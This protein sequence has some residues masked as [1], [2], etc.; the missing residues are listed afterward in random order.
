[1]TIVFS[2]GDDSEE[3]GGSGADAGSAGDSTGPG[4][5][6]NTGGRSSAAGDSSSGGSST[7]GGSKSTMG[8]EAG[9]VS[10]QG[11]DSGAGTGGKAPGTGGAATGG[12]MARGG[13]G[14]RT[15]GGAS[16]GGASN[17]GEGGGSD[18]PECEKGFFGPNCEPCTCVGT[19]T[20]DDGADGDGSCDCPTGYA[21][22]T[23]ADCALGYQDS[24]ADGTCLIACTAQTCSGHGE[25]GYFVGLTICDCQTGYAGDVC[26]TCDVG[27]QDNDD[28]DTCALS[29]DE[30]TC[31][32][33][34]TCDD[35]SGT[36]VCTCEEEYDGDF[37]DGCDEG[38]GYQDNDGDDICTPSCTNPEDPCNE[39]GTCDDSSGTAECDCDDGYTGDA[40]E[41]CDEGYIDDGNG[42]CIEQC[43]EYPWEGPLSI[44]DGQS[45]M[46]TFSV[47]D[48]FEVADVDLT[49]S[50]THTCMWDMI[51]TL[52]HGATTVTVVNRPCDD[53]TCGA[54]YIGATLDD[55]GTADIQTSCGD[56]LTSPP[57]F[58]PANPLSGFNT[59]ASEGDW[60]VT[61]SDVEPLLEG[62]FDSATL[63]LCRPDPI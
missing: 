59:M 25:C 10:A 26:N 6:R 60:V 8:G 49:L 31:N 57:T 4:G 1:L 47:L 12:T 62:T 11:G 7:T 39:H 36:R 5:A 32:D 29:C 33:H 54:N 58:T 45:I 44:L 19:A 34:G 48:E 17:A 18:A 35:D 40:C 28:N 2:C 53:L 14:G 16:S 42:N 43:T 50:I 38:G 24:D 41:S 13:G 30:N 37:C 22:T 3:E 51:T 23:C 55:D 46:A 27:Y 61:I 9:A 21:G 15:T 20:C 52:A 56:N 63:R